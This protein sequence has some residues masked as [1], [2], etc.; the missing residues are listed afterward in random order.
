MASRIPLWGT[1][2]LGRI[3]AGA[4]SA[5]SWCQ[6][7][8]GGGPGRAAGS[9]CR[10]RPGTRTPTRW[11]EGGGWSGATVNDTTTGTSFKLGGILTP[12][13]GVNTAGTVDRVEYYEWSTPRATCLQQRYSAATFGLPVGTTVTTGPGVHVCEHAV[14][15]TSP[16]PQPEAEPRP[17]VRP[18]PASRPAPPIR[19]ARREAV[20]RPRPS[21]VRGWGRRWC[22]ARHRSNCACVTCGCRRAS[23][24]IRAASAPDGALRGTAARIQ[25]RE[26][27]AA[28]LPSA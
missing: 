22:A 18:V 6:D 2:R 14:E 17:G 19:D 12:A 11:H 23:S 13:T 3:V 9:T 25:P 15:C 28:G 10:G 16:V 27:P 4:G 26:V 21:P 1:G 5:G 20:P 24:A 7:F 8:G